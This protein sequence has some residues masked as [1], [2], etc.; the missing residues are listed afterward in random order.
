[1]SDIVVPGFASSELIAAL[2]KIFDEYSPE[3]RAKFIKQVCVCVNSFFVQD[4]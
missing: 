3:E 2:A 1:M 4:D